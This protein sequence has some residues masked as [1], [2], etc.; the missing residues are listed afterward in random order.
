MTVGTLGTTPEARIDEIFDALLRLDYRWE[1]VCYIAALSDSE[2][3]DA[4][5]NFSSYH[6]DPMEDE[7]SVSFHAECLDLLHREADR[8]EAG[9]AKWIN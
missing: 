2:I 9:P 5:L 3:A 7:E 4:V 8:R 6:D 1:M